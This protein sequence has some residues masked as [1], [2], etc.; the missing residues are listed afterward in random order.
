MLIALQPDERLLSSVP[1]AISLVQS[2]V[3][4][5]DWQRIDV[6]VST[7]I[8]QRS[9]PALEFLSLI[10]DQVPFIRDKV[11]LYSDFIRNWKAV[12]TWLKEELSLEI[13]Q[14]QFQKCKVASLPTLRFVP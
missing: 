4:L 3:P 8:Q 13:G 7:T 14:L 5:L 2:D 10:T 9:L 12:G 6:A 1:L 11:A